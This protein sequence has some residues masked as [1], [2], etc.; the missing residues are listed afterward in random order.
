[1]VFDVSSPDS[2][3]VDSHCHLD[4]LDLSPYNGDLSALVLAAREAGVREML[5]VSVS[6]E[7]VARCIEIA[8]SDPHIMASVGVHPSDIQK[9]WDA[10]FPWQTFVQHPK[11]IAI[12]ETGLDYHYG[13][14]Q[15]LEQCEAF[16]AQI[17]M[18]K[19][20][21]KPLIVHTR[22]AKADTLALLTSYQAEKARGVLH[23]FTEDQ[24]MA[25]K[26]LDLG[27]YISFS[28]ILTFKNAEPLR[29][30][31]RSLPL[32]RILIETDS[33]YLAPIPHRGK[34]CE[35]KWV[36]EVAR[37]IA[38]LKGVSLVEVADQTRQNFYNLFLP[39]QSSEIRVL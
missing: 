29:D 25:F 9:G 24:D 8:E 17:E 20:V 5:C 35:P 12:G 13:L 27:F 22:A 30:V 4:R 6:F 19:S 14:E 32:D 3:F 26:A 31:V 28:G 11:V 33:P 37:K 15:K 21:Q 39:S 7:N 38:E 2:Y 1:M 10:R 36:V 23:C 34:S 16:V 18:A